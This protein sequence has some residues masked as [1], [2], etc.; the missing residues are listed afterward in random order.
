M[1]EALKFL[2]FLFLT[3]SFVIHAVHLESTITEQI[4]NEL[5]Y[6]RILITTR[7]GGYLL[8]AIS[9]FLEPSL[10]HPHKNKEQ[11][12]KDKVQSRNGE[13]QGVSGALMISM[14]GAQIPG[15]VAASMFFPLAGV[16]VALLYLYKSTYGLEFH[17]RRVAYA[18]FILSLFELISL[19]ELFIG[20]SNVS[21]FKLAAPFASLWTLEHLTL[22]IGVLILGKWVFSYLLKRLQTQLYIFFSLAILF[23]F[24]IS[25]L[26]F[27]WLLLGN[28]QKEAENQLETSVKVLEYALDT[29]KSELL[30]D[31][32]VFAQDAKVTD[33]ISADQKPQLA[34]LASE[35]LL[36]KK[37]SF[38]TVVNENGQVVARGEEPERI[39]DSLSSNTLIK[40][41]LLSESNF[42]VMSRDGVLAPDVFV[43]ASAP[44]KKDNEVIGAVWVGVVTDNAFVDGIYKATG[45]N[46]SIYGEDKI[47]ATSLV[48]EDGSSRR[49]GVIESNSEIKE[50]VLGKGEG[51]TGTTNFLN[52]P[53]F[54]S[55][56]PLKDLDNT[57]VGML[58]VGKP[59]VTI[60][61]TAGRSIQ[62]SFIVAGILW[63]LAIL[64]SYLISSYISKQLK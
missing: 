26:S 19:R 62:G 6:E 29:R 37:L 50:Q 57:P 55:Y 64:P 38:L 15:Y 21:V 39:G 51:F 24:V 49:V 3:V 53:Y 58:S 60:L 59:Q 45:L 43:S 7:L 13:L 8:I 4:I 20:N 33:A 41:S 22:F 27:T 46:A 17:L 30:S 25:T 54:V 40:R 12:I 63:L 2:G 47:S 23:I 9:L 1:D 48:G 34:N 35:Y 42:S 31:A 5:A 61:A 44:V 52:T 36:T 11:R 16:S 28:V 32:Q 56:L 14:F 10:S 18:F